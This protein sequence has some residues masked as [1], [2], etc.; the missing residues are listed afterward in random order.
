MENERKLTPQSLLQIIKR[1]CILYPSNNQCICKMNGLIG[2]CGKCDVDICI[3][4]D[5]SDIQYLN[6]LLRLISCHTA[7]KLLLKG[8]NPI[9]YFKQI[10]NKNEINK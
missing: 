8:T 1:D 7:V 6:K 10:K 4:V 9:A 5:L 2:M 3:N